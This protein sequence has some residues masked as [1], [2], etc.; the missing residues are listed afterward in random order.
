MFFFCHRFLFV[1][2]WFWWLDVKQQYN[3]TRFGKNLLI[4]DWYH[5]GASIAFIF[6]ISL[7]LSP[8]VCDRFLMRFSIWIRFVLSFRILGSFN[9][10][11]PIGQQNISDMYFDWIFSFFF[12]FSFFLM[13]W[14]YFMYLFFCS[15]FLFLY[16]CCMISDEC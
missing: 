1:I 6:C 16:F 15:S 13:L 10:S 5:Q 2:C 4:T 7:S 11:L 3:L 14:Y 8:G 9:E 12:I